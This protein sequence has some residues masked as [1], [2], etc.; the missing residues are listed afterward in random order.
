MPPPDKAVIRCENTG[1]RGDQSA[2]LPLPALRRDDQLQ[3]TI[4]AGPANNN[5]WD[6]T[7][8]THFFLE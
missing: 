5:A 2:D 8:I 3:V 6:W 7:Y 1:D 4:G